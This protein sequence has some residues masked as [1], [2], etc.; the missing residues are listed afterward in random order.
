MAGDPVSGLETAARRADMSDAEGGVATTEKGS[1]AAMKCPRSRGW[2]T[3]P[4]SLALLA[5]SLGAGDV[6]DAWVGPS[7]VWRATSRTTRIPGPAPRGGSWAAATRGGARGG[8]EGVL[9]GGG[10]LRCSSSASACG[11]RSWLGNFRMS[12]GAGGSSSS[13]KEFQIQTVEGEEEVRGLA[14]L[15]LES[16]YGKQRP[17]DYLNP[18]GALQRSLVFEQVVE[19]LSMRVRRYKVGRDPS[20]YPSKL[21][22]GTQRKSLEFCHSLQGNDP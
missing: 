17:V 3:L 22:K 8:R 5:L 9:G 21:N 11:R 19:D 6:A 1:K 12:S 16:F 20:H 4:T 14:L 18:I 13:N 7:A 2:A 15:C 10:M